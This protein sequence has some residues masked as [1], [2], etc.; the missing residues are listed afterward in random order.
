[1][2]KTEARTDFMRPTPLVPQVS[3]DGSV[4]DEMMRTIGPQDLYNTWHAECMARL[5]V[6]DPH[7]II[8]LGPYYDEMTRETY[9]ERVRHEL[10]MEMTRTSEVGFAKG[11]VKMYQLVASIRYSLDQFEKKLARE[12]PGCSWKLVAFRLERV[13]NTISQATVYNGKSHGVG[14]AQHAAMSSGIVDEK[15]GITRPVALG[16]T[17]D[18]QDVPDYRAQVTVVY[19]DVVAGAV[20]DPNVQHE[21]DWD[22]P[23][24]LYARTRSIRHLSEGGRR[25]RVKIVELIREFYQM[26]APVE[27][28]TPAPQVQ[29]VS[30]AGVDIETVRQLRKGGK[31]KAPMN[32]EA[33]AMKLG[34]EVPA[35]IAMLERGEMGTSDV[36]R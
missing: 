29:Q 32:P 27:E 31:G 7:K 2:G 19:A 4:R 17:V 35:V 16:R 28:V 24:V 18:Y 1:M 36:G 6:V 22:G 12:Q 8:A 14:S 3:G 5:H 34:L 13:N 20:R 15:E 33:I 11:A 25:R 23:G 21:R 9:D 10:R 26:D 30:I